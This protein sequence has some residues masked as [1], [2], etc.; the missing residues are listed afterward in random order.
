MLG[1]PLPTSSRRSFSSKRLSFTLVNQIF[2]EKLPP[3]SSGPQL[4]FLDQ[5]VAMPD[6]SS[7]KQEAGFSSL[8]VHFCIA[9]NIIVTHAREIDLTQKG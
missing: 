9:M 1:H 3:S 7:S 8:R 2:A 5:A 4:C 6:C